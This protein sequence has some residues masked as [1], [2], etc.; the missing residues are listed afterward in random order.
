MKHSEKSILIVLRE[1]FERTKEHNT[2]DNR[3]YLIGMTTISAYSENTEIAELT[4][5]IN[6]WI[7]STHANGVI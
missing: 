7:I 2:C 3:M 6:N 1:T 4:S 5:T